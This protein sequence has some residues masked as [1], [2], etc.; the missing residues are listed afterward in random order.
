MDETVEDV[1][2]WSEAMLAR[3]ASLARGCRRTWWVEVEDL[4]QE[5]CVAVLLWSTASGV[6]TMPPKLFTLVVRRRFRD[7]YNHL[8]RRG[9]MTTLAD[10]DLAVKARCDA[11]AIMD[12][13]SLVEGLPDRVRYAVLGRAYEYKS[14][15]DLAASRGLQSTTVAQHQ[16][17][18]YAMLRGGLDV[19]YGPSDSRQPRRKRVAY[20]CRKLGVNWSTWGRI[21]G[22]RCDDV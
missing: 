8:H 3:L 2:L 21:Q 17:E 19:G 5:G 1:P 16:T 7:Y 12:V 6:K 14:F 10:R 15:K 22:Q 13:R 20:R 11:D 4:V 9:G 18:A